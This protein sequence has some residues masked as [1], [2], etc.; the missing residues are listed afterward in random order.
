MKIE[1]P[2]VSGSQRKSLSRELVFVLQ[3]NVDSEDSL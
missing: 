1:F 2:P 3:I